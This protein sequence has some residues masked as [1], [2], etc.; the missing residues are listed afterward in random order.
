MTG[1]GVSGSGFKSQATPNWDDGWRPAAQVVCLM[2]P[3]VVMY[4]GDG[5]LERGLEADLDG[6]G[7]LMQ[8]PALISRSK[9]RQRFFSTGAGACNVPRPLESLAPPSSSSCFFGSIAMFLA[10]QPI[11]RQ[12]SVWWSD[13]AGYGVLESICAGY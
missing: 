9:D 5:G 10:G 4:P 2:D 3:V 8:M 13:G 1:P 7:E 6:G 12:H 11:N